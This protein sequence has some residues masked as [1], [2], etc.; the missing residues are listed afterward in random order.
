MS[1]H[2]GGSG[3]THD[4]SKTVLNIIGFCFDKWA[5]ADLAPESDCPTPNMLTGKKMA[6]NDV[7]QHARKLLD[8][9]P[10][11]DTQAEHSHAGY[12]RRRA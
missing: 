6:Y 7:L 2:A 9:L 11:G 1:T 10:S 3:M 8:Q 4:D 5:E 12:R